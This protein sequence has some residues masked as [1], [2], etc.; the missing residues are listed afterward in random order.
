MK[1]LIGVIRLGAL[2]A[3][4]VVAHRKTL[5]TKSPDHQ[6]R[7]KGEPDLS[8]IDGTVVARETNLAPHAGYGRVCSEQNSASACGDHRSACP[9]I[10]GD[11]G[12]AVG[13]AA[14]ETPATGCD[15]TANGAYTLR[16]MAA[17]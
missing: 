2:R 14:A 16:S 6:L 13:A 12:T 10:A 8:G 9:I 11:F 1:Q 17:T 15:N 3:A 7:R 5:A 4:S